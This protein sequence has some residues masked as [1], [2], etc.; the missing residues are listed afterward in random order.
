MEETQR[1]R[2]REKET[3]VN[4]IESETDKT[5]RNGYIEKHRESSQKEATMLKVWSLEF[6]KKSR[7]R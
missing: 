7:F 1:E 6:K 3:K 4:E 2:E 5:R